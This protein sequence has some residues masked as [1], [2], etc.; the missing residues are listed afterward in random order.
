MDKMAESIQW[1][2]KYWLPKHGLIWKWGYLC[3]SVVFE[4]PVVQEDH[5]VVSILEYVLTILSRGG[6]SSCSDSCEE[7]GGACVKQKVGIYMQGYQNCLWRGFLL[8]GRCWQGTGDGLSTQG[9]NFKIIVKIWLYLHLKLHCFSV[10]L[11][12]THT[13]SQFSLPRSLLD[14]PPT[15][16]FH[17]RPKALILHGRGRGRA[18]AHVLQPTLVLWGQGCSSCLA[19]PPW[20]F[21]CRGG[22]PWGVF[23][24]VKWV[25]LPHALVH[26]DR[27][28]LQCF[29]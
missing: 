16:N 4:V 28:K 22:F 21:V 19:A 13:H 1:G 12:Y 5:S 6:G 26:V 15:F 17:E 14:P 25:S 2:F 23:L 18:A 8:S 3:I 11:I 10:P 24:D 20:S 7:M 29:L 9:L 27:S